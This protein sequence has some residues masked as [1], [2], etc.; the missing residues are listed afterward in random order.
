VS[1]EAQGWYQDPSGLHDARYFSAGHPTRLVR[2]GNVESYDEPP[3]GMDGKAGPVTAGRPLGPTAA[4]ASDQGAPVPVPAPAP[5]P[6]DAD[7]VG[8]RRRRR[9]RAL[10]I[11]AVLVL[12]V[13]VVV[14]V[15]R[16]ESPGSLSHADDAVLVRSIDRT[17][18]QGS[19]EMT[20][21]G[22]I[23]TPDGTIPVT[24]LGE[25]DF[26]ADAAK[27]VMSINVSSLPGEEE[28]Q[29]LVGGNL[30]QTASTDGANTVAEVTHGREWVQMPPADSLN[31]NLDGRD[32]IVALAVFAAPDADV[33]ILG[34]QVVDGVPCSGYSLTVSQQSWNA[35]ATKLDGAHAPALTTVLSP[36]TYTT[37]FDAQGLLRSL[38]VRIQASGGAVSSNLTLHFGNYGSDVTI[39][40]PPSAQVIGYRAFLR[41]AGNQGLAGP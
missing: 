9:A 17:L 30:Y 1:G 3:P 22:T 40:A 13:V 37:C 20:V 36:P 23:Q 32:P 21:S 18:A 12:A 5:V 11:V 7:V 38:S 39:A 31:A 2:D 8:V 19:A 35:A 14:I 4:A 16:S 33:R 29:I 24:G 10:A 27:V 15:R 34:L 25:V 41:I 26:R 6:P 28:Q